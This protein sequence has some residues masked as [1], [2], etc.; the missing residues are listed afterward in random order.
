M[1]YRRTYGDTNEGNKH[2]IRLRPTELC[3][4]PKNRGGAYPTGLR[5]QE[6]LEQTAAIG[7]L[8]E[9]ADHNCVAVQ[10][11]PL[12]EILKR[13]GHIS[14][15]DYNIEQCAKDE[16]LHGLYDEPFNIVHTRCWHT[17]TL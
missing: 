9:E 13:K 12:A 11:M 16:I 3:C 5:V 17:T 15:L 1:K 4:H 2:T 10:E 8:Q 14:S 6:L 7:I